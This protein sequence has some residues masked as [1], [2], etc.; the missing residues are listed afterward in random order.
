MLLLAPGLAS[1]TIACFRSRP[2]C[3]VTARATMSTIPPAGDGTKMWIARFGYSLCA[4]APA[5]QPSETAASPMVTQ[6]LRSSFIVLAMKNVKKNGDD[7]EVIR[8]L[9]QA[10]KSCQLLN[11]FA[12]DAGIRLDAAGEWGFSETHLRPNKRVT[13][14]AHRDGA[15]SLVRPN[16]RESSE[17]EAHGFRSVGEVR[18]VARTIAIVFRSRGAAATPRLART[19]GGQAR[20]RS[21]HG[22]SAGQG[23]RRGTVESR[24]SRTR[25]RRAGNAAYKSR[26]RPACGD[27]G[28]SVLGSRSVQL[29]GARRAQHDRAAELRDRRAEAALVAPASGSANPLGFWHD[30]TGRRLFGCD[31]HRDHHSPGW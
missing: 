20:T 21:V 27:H 11:R 29:P 13:K 25:R 18:T 10:G 26:I 28:P 14:Q 1:T 9:E 2:T 6:K 5:M 19:C 24:S 30:R 22:R 7:I 15:V 23:A 4:S 3:S 12:N 31:Q 17:G 8:N 16:E